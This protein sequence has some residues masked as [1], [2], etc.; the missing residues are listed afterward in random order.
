[1]VDLPT[2]LAASF[3]RSGTFI[4]AAGRSGETLH[5]PHRILRDRQDIG[6][7][8][9]SDGTDQGLEAETVRYLHGLAQLVGQPDT[10]AAN[11]E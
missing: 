1:M 10:C 2:A 6:R 9:E 7:V 3:G 8:R 4:I 5:Q 11:P